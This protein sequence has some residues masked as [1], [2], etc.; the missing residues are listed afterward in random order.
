MTTANGTTTGNGART[1]VRPTAVARNARAIAHDVLELAEL[2][3]ELLKVDARDWV[4]RL[5]LPI[6]LVAVAL[7]AAVGCIPIL[8]LS[9]ARLLYELIDMPFSLALLISG[10]VGLFI[11]VVCG[12]VGWKRLSGSVSVFGRSREELQR[13]IRWIKRVLHR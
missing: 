8:L 9:L 10:V 11:A 1:D 5:V 3:T 12:L 2:Q 13:N 4:K 7:A 6:V